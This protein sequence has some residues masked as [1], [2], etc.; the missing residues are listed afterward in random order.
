MLKIFIGTIPY[1]IYINSAHAFSFFV[2][3]IDYETTKISSRFMMI[4]IMILG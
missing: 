2:A 1:H 3:A 4:N